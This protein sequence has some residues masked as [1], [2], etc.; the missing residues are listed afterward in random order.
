MTPRDLATVYI[1]G[2][3]FFI[4]VRPHAGNNTPTTQGEGNR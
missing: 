4:T 2:W 3:P 1:S